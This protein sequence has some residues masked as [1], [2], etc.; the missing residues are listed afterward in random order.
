MYRCAQEYEYS[1]STCNVLLILTLPLIDT[2][3]HMIFTHDFGKIKDFE[4]IFPS[5]FR[6]CYI[7]LNSSALRYIDLVAKSAGT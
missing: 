3:V 5:Q 6:K 7:L 1:K 2:S 4:I